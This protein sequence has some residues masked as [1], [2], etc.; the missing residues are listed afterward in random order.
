[1]AE[2]H[3]SAERLAALREQVA[4]LPVPAASEDRRAKL[5]AMLLVTAG[6]IAIGV[7]WWGAS[8]T[9]DVSEQIPF[10]ISGGILGLALV[11]LGAAVFVAHALRSFLRFWLLRVLAEQRST[12]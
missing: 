4:A 11:L 7:G 1:M 5:V 6:F 9:R 3:E 10:L 12:E 2:G 8:G